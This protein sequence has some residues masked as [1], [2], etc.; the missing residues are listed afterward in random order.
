MFRLKRV[1]KIYM[2]KKLVLTQADQVSLKD[3]D[4]RG[5][6]AMLHFT[7]LRR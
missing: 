2:E 3:F 6:A 5:S 7:I 1:A 4:V